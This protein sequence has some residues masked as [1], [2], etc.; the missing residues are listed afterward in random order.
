MTT[1]NFSAL[2][3]PSAIALVGASNQAGSVGA[4]LARNL[5]E[6]GFAG[7]IWPVNPRDGQIL[8]RPCFNSIS[9][10]PG[11]PDLAVIAT[12]PSAIPGLIGELGSRNCRAAIVITAGLDETLRL[13]MLRAARPHLMRI[14]GPNCLGMLSPLRGTNASFSHL[15]P[16]KGEIAFLT[17][18]GAIATSII[19]W[20]NGRGVGF[21]HILS[22][23]DM[24][25]VDFGDL[26]DYLAFDA[27]TKSILL[28]AETIT[29]ARKFMSAA[30]IAARA[31]PVIIVK[32][33]RSSSGAKAAASHTGAMA[34]ADAVYDA[35]FRRAG[36]LRVDTL[37]DL[38]DAAETLASGLRPLGDRLIILTNGG[39]LGVLA[40]DA[41]ERGG[42]VLAPLSPATM[43]ALDKAL[44]PAWSRGNPVDILGDAHGDRYEAALSVLG[45]ETC[46]ALLVM[47]C[48]TG[49]GDSREAAEAVL[50]A[51]KGQP[52]RPW[53]GCWMG[54]ATAGAPRRR[55][56]EAKIPNYE[57]PDEAVAAF[58]SL[59]QYA[60]NQE[61]LLQ[62]PAVSAE[63]TPDAR[64]A[65]R[66]LIE[67]VQ[68]EKRATLTEPEAKRVLAAYGV[69]VV[70]TVTVASPE[71]AA[72]AAERL[73]RSVALKI[74]SRQITHKSDVGGVRLDLEGAAAVEAAAREMLERVSRAAPQARVDGFAVQAM[75]RRPRA[76]ELILGAS[77]DATF[78]PCLMFGHGGVATEI[79]ADKTMELPPLNSVLATAMIAR[80]RVAKLLAGYRDR[81]AA[82]I[83]AVVRALISLSDLI[84]DFPEIA[85]LDINPLLADEHGVIAL[86]ARIIVGGAGQAP[87]LAIRPYPGELARDVWIGADRAHLRPV[88]PQDA[89][90]VFEMIERTERSDVYLRFRDGAAE[91]DA[92]AAARLSQIDY[93]RE[94]A[95][96]AVEPDGAVAG[97]ARLVFDPEF[98]SGEYAVIVR[99]DVQGRGLGTVLLQ[100]LLDFA[101]SRGARRLW[102]DVLTENRQMLALARELGATSAEREDAPALTRTEF[103]LDA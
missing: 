85:E 30:R 27:A 55:L 73:G 37:R 14:V 65:V 59:A 63:Q 33:G 82:D 53:L 17:Q 42:G 8:G 39:G 7:E 62:T 48:P 60:R 21:S 13:G 101:K 52:E 6:G 67:Q 50:E 84:I 34:G 87:R 18:S 74:L 49:V 64:A 51:R 91:M 36:M 11:A 103:A 44:P 26:L 19:D 2:F 25:D 98:E 77:I 76:H 102:A 43:A 28:Y 68:S 9:A 80:T 32:G 16:L 93:D 38:F 5:F 95:L 83:D 96:I 90:A 24:S 35:A 40:A 56:S 79:V 41:L 97:M 72:A 88:R 81:R 71:A 4:V 86:D 22:L 92:R 1:R 54:E 31:K 69:P 100:A 58:L 29:H 3:E 61:A 12:P 10:L 45:R 20:A 75:V 99:S 89:T 47:N 23:G 78:G 70:E 57:T 66:K 15:A 94:M 46:D